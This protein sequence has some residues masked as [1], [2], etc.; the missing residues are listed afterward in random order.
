MTSVQGRAT[1]R[2]GLLWEEVGLHGG[3][4]GV[5]WA[6]ERK[7]WVHAL[8]YRRRKCR[9]EQGWI[10]SKV[11]G[12]LGVESGRDEEPRELLAVLGHHYGQ[13]SQI[14]D[15][16]RDERG[17]RQRRRARRCGQREE[18][19]GRGIKMG[20]RRQLERRFDSGHPRATCLA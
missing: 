17:R 3:L 19:R 8:L 15:G 12:L 5:L 11:H 16:E 6:I 9:R 7:R 20:V 13:L 1:G 2:A 10:G 4:K 18:K 14:Y